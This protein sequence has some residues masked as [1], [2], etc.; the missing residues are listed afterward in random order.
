MNKAV[1][2][3]RVKNILNFF[4]FNTKKI[5][6]WSIRQASFESSL[7]NL[8]ENLRK[9][10]PDISNV[11]SGQKKR[12]KNLNK[13]Y[14]ELK[15]RS[16]HAFQSSL[17]LKALNYFSTSNLTVADIGDSSGTHMIYLKELCKGKL[18]L[19]TISVNLDPTAIKKIQSKGLKA[20]LCRAEDL[21]MEGTLIDLFVS[22]EMV[23][24]LHNP[25]LFFRRLA[26]KSKC[27][28]MIITVPYVKNSRVGL[29][30]IRK[31]S[32]KIISSE[33]EHIFELNPEDWTLLMLHSG[34]KVIYSKIYYQYPR[35]WPILSQILRYYWRE[36]DFEGFWGA[37]LEKNT[38]LSDCYQDW[39]N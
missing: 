21:D 37:I 12:Q 28:K 14:W 32:K 17:M 3:T 36:T 24:H 26:K 15:R 6:T 7:S 34:W 33:E 23:E 13:S 27:N 1:F 20:V 19:D 8:A 25:A 9:I 16:L 29:Y 5:S 11:E 22:F 38:T 39:E 4:G 35:K 31:K 2:K 30:N 10:E 18:T